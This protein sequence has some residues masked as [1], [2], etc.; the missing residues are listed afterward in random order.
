M[1]DIFFFQAKNDK[2]EINDIDRVKIRRLICQNESVFTAMGGSCQ[3]LLY[4][5][6]L[7][8]SRSNLSSISDTLLSDVEEVKTKEKYLTFEDVERGLISLKE[9]S[10]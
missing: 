9:N 4:L 5:S 7:E 1:T 6:S 10:F 2:W 8:V 3:R